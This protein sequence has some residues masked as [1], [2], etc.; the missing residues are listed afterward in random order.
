[1]QEKHRCYITE[2]TQQHA[3]ELEKVRTELET[4]VDGLME[5]L[6]NTQ[7]KYGNERVLNDE[8]NN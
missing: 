6:A 4:E 2:L 1:M 5:D 3:S 7:E 8:L